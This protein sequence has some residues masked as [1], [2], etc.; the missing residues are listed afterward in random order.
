VLELVRTRIGPIHLG[1][2][3]PG[4]MRELHGAELRSLYTDVGL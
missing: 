3:R 2:Q 4:A 1:Q